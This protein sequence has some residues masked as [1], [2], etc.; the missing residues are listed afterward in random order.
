MAA[1]NPPAS[2]PLQLPPAIYISVV[3]TVDQTMVQRIAKAMEM[4]TAKD[5]GVR[6]IHVL[7]QST[8][9]N[10]GDGVFL[11]N[12]FRA[13][14]LDLHFYNLGTVASIAVVVFL[15]AKRRYA[16]AT[17]TFMIHKSR[18]GSNLA[19]SDNA[20]GLISSLTADDERTQGIFRAHLSFSEAELQKHLV[21]ELT[22][23]A[24]DAL[25]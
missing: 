23:T 10:V 8:G 19:T 7:F 15:G 4:A 6:S 3:G 24:A 9:G 12:Y 22:F 25:R 13:L 20:P 14:P 1:T 16:S 5:A 17:A 2:T 18:A 21:G 11:Y